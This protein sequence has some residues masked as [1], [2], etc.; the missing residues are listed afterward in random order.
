MMGKSH[1]QALRGVRGV[2]HFG[3]GIAVTYSIWKATDVERV[4]CAPAQL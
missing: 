1:D 2:H 3:A 4:V